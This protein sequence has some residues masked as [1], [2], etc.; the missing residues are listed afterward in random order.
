MPARMPWGAGENDLQ[1]ARRHTRLWLDLMMLGHLV[2]PGD[3]IRMTRL[4]ICT[5]TPSVYLSS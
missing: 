5:K 4:R 1:L 2:V 3:F